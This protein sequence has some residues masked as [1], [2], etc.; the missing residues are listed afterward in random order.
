EAG[1]GNLGQDTL[2]LIVQLS[3]NA[4]V[5]ARAGGDLFLSNLAGDLRIDQIY[6]PGLARIRSAGALVEVSADLQRDIQARYLRLF[7]GTTIGGAGSSELDALDLGASPD[8]WVELEAADGIHV[9]AVDG[10]L[11]VRSALAS[12]GDV[13][14]R[15]PGDLN[16]GT[17]EAGGKLMLDAAGDLMQSAQTVAAVGNI[18]LS[19]ARYIMADGATLRARDGRIDIATSGDVVVGRIE[20]TTN[21]T[22]QALRIIA[23]G[24]IHDGGDIGTFDLVAATPGAGVV[25]EATDGIGSATW[26]NGAPLPVADA[27]ETDIAMLN[28]LS[29]A[30]GV[31]IDEKDDVAI[32]AVD[33]DG[34][35][36]IKAGGTIG[37]NRAYTARGNLDLLSGNSVTVLEATA[38]TG[39]ATVI[40]E[41]DIIMDAVTAGQGV[42]LQAINGR[43]SVKRLAGDTLDISGKG[44]IDLGTLNV[45]STMSFSTESITARVIHTGTSGPLL[46]NVTG[47][48][49]GMARRVDLTF[50]SPIG[51]RFER[52]Y[53][54]DARI[55]TERGWL[56]VLDGRI[57]NQARF[58]NPQ[59][60]VYMDNVTTVIEPADIQLNAP[61]GRF[62]LRLERFRLVTDELALTRS[63]LHEVV[64][65]TDPDNSG[66]EESRNAIEGR[67]PN[68]TRPQAVNVVPALSQIAINIPLDIPAV[69]SGEEETEEEAEAR[70]NAEEEAQRETVKETVW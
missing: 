4:T 3:Q 32:G 64:N 40:A 66:R 49:G 68:P 17:L 70:R 25:L 14:L 27:L 12:A 39:N 42:K 45:K 60:T 28:A 44:D 33:A 30:G 2:D 51:T 59:S 15:S 46:M 5:T 41:Q 43:V 6:T 1:S 21:A 31:L 52:L 22:A 18:D 50:D 23:G 63:P 65:A 37:G 24:G 48:R 26:N 62:A 54:R 11:D 8:G 61:D 47:P 13:T 34:D 20:A 9:R 38:E 57:D 36:S 69:N 19:A 16:I 67:V 55:E 7:A 29:T 10:A 58:I 35:L 56:E 53:S